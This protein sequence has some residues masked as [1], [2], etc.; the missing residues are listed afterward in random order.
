MAF[1][2]HIG[3]ESYNINAG[4]MLYMSVIKNKKDKILSIVSIPCLFLINT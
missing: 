2:I 4:N 1:I 3:K